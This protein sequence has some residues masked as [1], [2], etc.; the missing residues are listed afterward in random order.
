MINNPPRSYSDEEPYQDDFS[1]EEPPPPVSKP[2]P[3]VSKPSPP[4]KKIEIDDSDE[5][6]KKFMQKDSESEYESDEPYF[7]E[8]ITHPLRVV[9][10]AY[11]VKL[12]VG[13][14]AKKK[15]TYE[16]KDNRSR[17]FKIVSSHP[18]LMA[19]KDSTLVINEKK[20]G[21]I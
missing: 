21:K 13:S 4:K 12:P 3:P 17:Q 15:I 1:D 16:N 14:A 10:K 7:E 9:T 8:E 18:E 5:E 20:K 6:F 2:P 19:I 11:N